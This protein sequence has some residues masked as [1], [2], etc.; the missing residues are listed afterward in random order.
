MWKSNDLRITYPTTN[1]LNLLY[2]FHK[3]LSHISIILNFL[4]P[5]SL[6]LSFSFWMFLNFSTANT[7]DHLRL[8]DTYRKVIFG[9][10]TCIWMSPGRTKVKKP[11]QFLT[12]LKSDKFDS[13]FRLYQRAIRKLL[14]IGMTP[15]NHD[16]SNN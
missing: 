8:V 4:N 5:F 10:N 14:Y 15:Y 16:P 6:E 7:S 12:Q 9:N 1:D 2:I 13:L 3:L 11:Q